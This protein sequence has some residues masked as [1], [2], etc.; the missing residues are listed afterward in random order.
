MERES[1]SW[2]WG[3]YTYLSP[4]DGGGQNYGRSMRTV[5][6]SAGDGR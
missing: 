6:T 1:E 2:A 5:L 3:I 4:I